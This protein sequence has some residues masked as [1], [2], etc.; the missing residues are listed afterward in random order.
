MHEL[1]VCNAL[2]E[3]VENIALQ[4]RGSEVTRIILKIGPLSGVEH[5]LLRNAFPLAAA[6][7]VAE[8]ADLVI[9]TAIVVVK[10]SEC[11]AE[12]EVSA[13]RLLCASCG[14]FRTRIISGDELILQRV[15]LALPTLRGGIGTEAQ[16]QATNRR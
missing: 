14:D 10:C 1:S 5:Q 2:I 9:E 6:A 3:Q 11:A 13:N 15:E 12:S 4:H 8:K 7:T 16:S